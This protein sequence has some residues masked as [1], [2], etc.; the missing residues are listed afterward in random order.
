M[1]FNKTSASV[2]GGSEK[3]MESPDIV[4]KI[5]R[6][7]S[8]G[9]GKKRIAKE[10]GISPNT[11]KRYRRQGQWLPYSAPK[12]AKKLETLDVWLED[13]FTLHKGNAEVVRQELVRQHN[14]HANLRT[15]ERAVK[16]F[17]QKALVSAKATVRFE[18][19]PGKQMQIDFG[20]MSVKIAG[21]VT[22]IYFF[23]AV[24]GF[25]RRQYIQAFTHE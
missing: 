22:K 16:P 9:W 8:E 21:E 19:P 11:V 4:E 6:L 2:T 10:L 7:S 5:L 25:S 17:R 15:I 3:T 18:T 13:M 12:R 23:A 24:L 14:I 20:S 1:Q